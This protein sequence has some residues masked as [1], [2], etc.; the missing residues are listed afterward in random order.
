MSRSEEEQPAKGF[1]VEDRRRF[2][3]EGEL[4]PEFSGTEEP[5]APPPGVKGAGAAASAPRTAQPPGDGGAAARSAP[6][7]AEEMRSGAGARQA[8]AVAEINFSA[9]L[10]SL[11]TEALVHL[12]EMPDPSSGEQRRDLA[13]AQQMI[14]I[15]G[16]L[17]DK[18]RGNL[19]H[20]EQALLDAVLFDL[21]MKYVEIA[22][23]VG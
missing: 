1:K 7:A 10:M 21:R 14:D 18:T 8:G 22:R 16:M 5:S 12:G 17:R 13:M 6:R 3:A 20:D 4:K 9:F 2:S 23:R 15:L 11:S 19:D